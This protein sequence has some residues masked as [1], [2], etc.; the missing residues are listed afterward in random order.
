MYAYYGVLIYPHPSEDYCNPMFTK[1]KRCDGDGDL[2]SS[3]S[4]CIDTLIGDGTQPVCQPDVNYFNTWG[5]DNETLE[6]VPLGCLT[7]QACR[8]YFIKYASLSISYIANANIPLSFLK[9]S[10]PSSSYKASKISQSDFVLK[11]YFLFNFF[12]KS[13]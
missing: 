11:L 2:C 3:D 10:T 12:L 9:N 6:T 5:G 7:Q 8:E 13:T 4:D 1:F